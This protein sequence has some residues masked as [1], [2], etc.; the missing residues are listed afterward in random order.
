MVRK[1]E[2]EYIKKVFDEKPDGFIHY[3]KFMKTHDVI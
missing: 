1:E 3:R 2:L